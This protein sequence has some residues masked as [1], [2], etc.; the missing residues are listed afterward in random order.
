M[1]NN[2]PQ[3]GEPKLIFVIDD[4]PAMRLSC[5]KIL[6]KE[7]YLVETFED[8]QQGLERIQ[9]QHPDLLVVD[10]KMPRI[11]G[12]DVIKSVNKIDPNISLVV[13][14]GY[15][16]IDTAVEAMKA[17]AYDFL[18]K[19]FTPDELRLIVNRGLER[20]EFAKKSE[21]LA[22]ELQ[23]TNKELHQINKNYMEILG[24]VSHE[25]KNALGIMIGSAELIEQETLGQIND[26]QKEMLK[27]FLRNC[28]QLQDMIRNYLNLSRLEKGE[29]TIQKQ[30]I[31]Y[32]E[33]IIEPVVKDLLP[34]VQMRD[35]IIQRKIPESF[36]IYSDPDLLKIV[37]SNLLNNAIKY[38]KPNGKIRIDA[39]D[40]GD[41]WLLG[42]W[43]EGE[44]IPKEK[45][46]NLFSKFTRLNTVSSIHESGSGLGLYITRELIER[47]GG[48]IWAES[49]Y[50]KWIW[51]RFRLPKPKQE[52]IN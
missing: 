48:E 33:I 3:T 28:I 21:K 34:A 16:T 39:Q 41:K 2:L 46:S 29:I 9:K 1:S 44:G 49:D 7:Q 18:P 32:T 6:K 17:G 52:K 15:A 50:G 36:M 19:P 23:N 27:I 11:G 5:E 4:D 30:F 31:N 43:N 42:V 8:G 24:F 47:Q 20:S 14:T 12:I 45:L 35:M 26:S 38:G 10:L 13:I 40:S 22:T 25:V 37:L 51:F